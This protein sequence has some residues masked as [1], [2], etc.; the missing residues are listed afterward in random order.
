ML[1]DEE[2][3]TLV[4]LARH[5]LESHLGATTSIPEPSV[6]AASTSV[7]GVF[8]TL[9]CDGN[10]RGCIGYVLSHVDLAQITKRAVIAAAT[11][12]PRFASVTLAELPR[13][14]INITVLAP[15]EPIGEIEE[16]QIGRDGLVVER[17]GARGLLLPQVASERGWDRL[18]FLRETCVKAGLS[19]ESWREQETL[20][21]R[22]A[23]VQFEE[24]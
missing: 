13:V 5:T 19:E 17:A 21:L 3:R 12:D 1:T 11:N 20:V 9:H 8:A 24:D 7:G 6:D 14:R 22:F 2:G 18:R 16:I 15:P 10:L 23:A 4:R